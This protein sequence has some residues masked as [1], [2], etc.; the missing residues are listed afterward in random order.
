[1]QVRRENSIEVSL[2][3]DVEPY[4]N[5]ANAVQFHWSTGGDQRGVGWSLTIPPADFKELA[6]TMIAADRDAALDAFASAIKGR[7]RKAIRRDYAL[8]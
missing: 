8:G 7:R 4:V 1:M 2:T 3:V 6:R 5:W